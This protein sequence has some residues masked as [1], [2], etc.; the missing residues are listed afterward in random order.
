M[1]ISAQRKL[2]F[3]FTASNAAESHLY[4]AGFQQ[5]V[6]YELAHEIII[7]EVEEYRQKSRQV[8]YVVDPGEIPSLDNETR[9]NLC[10]IA[11]RQFLSKLAIDNFP[12]CVLRLEL[13]LEPWGGQILT[14]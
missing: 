5:R 11:V 9:E 2:G 8:A 7:A 10:R 1:E 12:P 14:V 13:T 6:S 4:F 3:F